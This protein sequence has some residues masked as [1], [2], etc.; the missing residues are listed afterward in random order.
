LARNAKNR[1]VNLLSM[2]AKSDVLGIEASP[3]N[4]AIGESQE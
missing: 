1:F 2:S 4:R 3:R